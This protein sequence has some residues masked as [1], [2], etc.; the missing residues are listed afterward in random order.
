MADRFAGPVQEGVDVEEFRRTGRTVPFKEIFIPRR[1]EGARVTI[2]PEGKIIFGGGGGVVPI[3]DVAERVKREIAEK[4]K[5][6]LKAKSIEEKRK[7]EVLRKAQEQF[8]KEVEAKSR[9]ERVRRRARGLSAFEI[10]KITQPER[11]LAK[12]IKFF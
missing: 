11:D 6:E 3:S 2:T 1:G 7:Q 12:A 4:I 8:Q 10:A 9:R 5:I